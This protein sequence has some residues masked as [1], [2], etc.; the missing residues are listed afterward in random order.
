MEK[1]PEKDQYGPV[2]AECIG[3]KTLRPYLVWNP[4][5]TTCILESSRFKDNA[6]CLK[7]LNRQNLN[8]HLGNVELSSFQVLW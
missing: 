2:F 3:K 7:I 5:T 4:M 8:D 1:T 6:E